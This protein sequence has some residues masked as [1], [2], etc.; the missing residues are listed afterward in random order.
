MFS[1]QL[2][3]LLCLS[4]Y[5]TG[6]ACYADTAVD[7]RLIQIEKRLDTIEATLVKN[8]NHISELESFYGTDLPLPNRPK[9]EIQAQIK[10]LQQQKSE[11]LENITP[12]HPTILSIDRKIRIL[13]W[14]VSVLER[15]AADSEDRTE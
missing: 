2:P 5:L 3:V 8:S 1:K 10:H 6:S 12:K 9:S 7:E 13:K 14:Q 15:L 4:L 11:Y